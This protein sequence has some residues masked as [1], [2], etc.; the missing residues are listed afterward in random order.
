MALTHDYTIVCELARPEMIG[1]KFFIVGLFPNGIATPVVP[2]PMPMISFLT[3]LKADEACIHDFTGR[4]SQLATGESVGP[5]ATGRIQ[6][7]GAGAVAL[8]HTILNPP[9]RAFGIHTWS[10]EIP[11][12]AP[13]V[14]QFPITQVPMPMGPQQFQYGP[15]R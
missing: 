8:V 1:G 7:Q 4:L 15:R 11:G 9:F 2:F 13:F 12:Y 10:V 3:L 14:T 6:T 5:P